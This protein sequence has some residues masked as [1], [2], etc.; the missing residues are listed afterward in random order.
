[1]QKLVEEAPSPILDDETRREMG[2]AAVCSE[3]Q[4]MKMREQLSLY[5]I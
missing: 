3:S 1:M 4:I 5:M 2:N